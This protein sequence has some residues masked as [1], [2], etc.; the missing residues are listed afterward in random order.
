MSGNS[1]LGSLTRGLAILEVVRRHGQIRP[2]DI[3]DRLHLPLST[4]YRYLATLK[5]EGYLIEVDGHLMPSARLAEPHAN[6]DR[7]L[8]YCSPVLRRLSAETAMTAV[9][10]V[11]V[12]T[13]ALCLD[14]VAAHP[15]H[16]IAH[17]PGEVRAL[18]AGA[19]ALPLLAYAPESILKG[20]LDGT[21]RRFTSA[22][23][24]RA[25]LI[26]AIESVRRDGHVIS[27]GH[28]TPGMIGIGVPVLVD[29]RCLCAL[30]LVA[31]TSLLSR[32]DSIVAKLRTSAQHLADHIPSSVLDEL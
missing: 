9:L 6:F 5:A 31:D 24:D 32:S 8:H 21:L 4:V 25:E 1:G 22:T 7:L 3:C 16:Q 30:S 26:R 23:P 28:M 15:K 17:Q 12:H 20:V 29:G 19:S 2:Q 13:A 10:T 11:R 27:E 14:C 18:H